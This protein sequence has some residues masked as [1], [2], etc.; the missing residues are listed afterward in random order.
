MGDDAGEEMSLM[1]GDYAICLT[2]YVSTGMV[3]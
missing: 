3:D 2:V 1:E